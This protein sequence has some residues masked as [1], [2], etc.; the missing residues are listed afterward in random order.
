MDTSPPTG[1]RP[2]DAERR[3]RA[4]ALAIVGLLAL[5]ATAILGALALW[6]ASTQPSLDGASPAPAASDTREAGDEAPEAS[7][8]AVPPGP[9][10]RG[11]PP[12]SPQEPDPEEGEEEAGADPPREPA[13]G[14]PGSRSYAFP[15]VPADA[16]SYGRDHHTYPATDIF[17]A[18]GTRLVAITDGVVDEAG[19]TDGWDPDVDDPAT[20]SG[21][22]VSIVGDDGVRYYLSHLETVEPGVRAGARVTAGTP[23]GTV[24]RSG[25][26]RSTPCHAHFGISPPLGPGDWE[27]RR[28]VIWPWPYLDAW[29][30]GRDESP[31]EEVAAWS[32]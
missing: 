19:D 31:A 23:I 26:A 6:W 21:R 16:A 9:G 7:E 13:T 32:P 4:P 14:S 3:R 15:V 2:P 22:Y 11:S 30:A 18:C 25:N 24:G 17:A 29:R 12:A 28:G 5:I 8:K 20:R 1:V 27:I 10:A